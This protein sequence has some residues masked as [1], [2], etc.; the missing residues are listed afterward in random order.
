MTAVAVNDWGSLWAPLNL[1]RIAGLVPADNTATIKTVE[2]GPQFGDMWVVEPGLQVG[3]TIVVDGL[4]RIKSGMTVTPTPFKD[5][6][7][8]ATP[9]G[10]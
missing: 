6:Q 8:N 3:D 10:Q 4:Q 2:F 7:G 9:S 1:L 5:T